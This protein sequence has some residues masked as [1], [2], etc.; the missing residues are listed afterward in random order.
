MRF[1]M[2]L[3]ALLLFCSS[4]SS[5]ADGIKVNAELRQAGHQQAGKEEKTQEGKQ[6]ITFDRAAVKKMLIEDGYSDEGEMDR[7]L[8][9]LSLI[10]AGLQGILDAYLAD[11]TIVD[12]FQVEGL[13][14]PIIMHKFECDFWNA[15]GFMNTSTHNRELAKSLYRMP[16]MAWKD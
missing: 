8:N 2:M 9:E 12:D 11:R 10:D 5:A 7:T 4:H 6:V 1:T 15:L 14:I 16:P 13:T 3:A